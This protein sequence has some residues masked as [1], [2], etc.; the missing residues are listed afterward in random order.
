MKNT[1]S[2]NKYAFS[3]END[4]FEILNPLINRD[5][6]GHNAIHYVIDFIN[7]IGK[8]YEEIFFFIINK[9]IKAGTNAALINKVSP[10][11]V[12]EFHVSL[13]QRNDEAPKVHEVNFNNQS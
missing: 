9:D 11:S 4:L 7:F 5:I 12:K 6:T 8:E 10:N 3:F 13:A 1:F 2:K